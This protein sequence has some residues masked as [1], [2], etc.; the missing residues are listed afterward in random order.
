M[1]RNAKVI[2]Y[3]GRYASLVGYDPE[4]TRTDKVP[5]VSAY[6]KVISSSYGNYPILLK[7]HEAPYNPESTITLLSEYQIREYDLV[8]DSV[9]RKHK[10]AYGKPGTQCFQV[11]QHVFINFE[12]RGD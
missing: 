3:T 6:L 12:D 1:G 9:A 2:S 8:I 4:N 10:S 7:V 5:I 11:S